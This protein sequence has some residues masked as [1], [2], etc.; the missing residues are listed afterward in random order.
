MEWAPN[1]KPERSAFKLLDTTFNLVDT[2]SGLILGFHSITENALKSANH[3]HFRV[4]QVKNYKNQ[5]FVF[6][7]TS[8][9]FFT[10]F[11]LHFFPEV[12]NIER[13]HAIPYKAINRGTQRDNL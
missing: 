13:W 11:N 3:A 8:L 6:S 1:I 2:K 7:L 10:F 4:Q 12:D 9:R 5:Y